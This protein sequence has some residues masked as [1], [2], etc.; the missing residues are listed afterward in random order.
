LML[1]HTCKQNKEN[2]ENATAGSR[3]Y[4]QDLKATCGR[5]AEFEGTF[6]GKSIRVLLN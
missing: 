2:G 5:I 6:P 4:R 3:Q 1:L